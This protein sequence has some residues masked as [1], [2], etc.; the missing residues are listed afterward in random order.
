MNAVYSP[1]WKTTRRGALFRRERG[2]FMYSSVY[3]W[4]KILRYLENQLTEPIVAAWFDDAELVEL[5]DNRIVLFSPS[6]F[7]KEIIQTRAAE[8]VKSA[9]KELFDSN[10]EL[11]VL[12]ED[13]MEPFHEKRRKQ[14]LW[15]FNPQFT[16]EKFVVG[17]SNRMAHAVAVAVANAPGAS[18]QRNPLF[19]Y[20]PSG[21]GKTHLL[22]A[23]AT[24]VHKNDANARI[25]YVSGEQFANELLFSI[26]EH[27]NEEFRQKYRSADLFLIDDIH[28]IAGKDSL[29]EEFFNTFNALYEAK[30]QI[31]MAADRPPREM[32]RLEERLRTRFEWGTLTE[33]TP[34]D[35]GTRMVILQNNAQEMG[36]D[37]PQEVCNFIAENVTSD[38]RKLEGALNILHAAWDLEKQP[39]TL[40]SAMLALK[41]IK[42]E[43]KT[44]PSA[45]LICSAV[46]RFYSIEDTVLRSTQK[47]KAVAEARQVAMYLM[48]TL[49]EFTTPEI[50]RVLNRDHSTVIYGCRR[51]AGLLEDRNTGMPDN[52]RDIIAD[53]RE[54]Q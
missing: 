4:S 14:E 49:G 33:I 20:G 1:L 3:I 41:N 48:N 54:H 26:R 47:N 44:K 2:L 7:R 11:L 10:V 24:Q 39:I 15:D 34:P 40:E 12:G 25:A 53:I 35:Y 9:M 16:F 38:V 13:E 46:C 50:G 42:P 37:L 29:Q 45:D 23:I 5:T 28:F 52:L 30:K 22:Y 6:P 43:V 21:L 27:R 51:I 8:H 31:V 18:K 17:S 32:P 36:L 19:I